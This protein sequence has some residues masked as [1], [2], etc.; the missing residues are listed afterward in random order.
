[1]NMQNLMMQAK[2]MQ[3]DIVKIQDELEKKTYEGKSQMVTILIN[4]K[5]KILSVNIDDSIFTSEDK[6][7]LEDM[8]LIAIN[9]ALEKM[10]TDKEEKLGKYSKMFNGL[11]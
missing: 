3:N 10:N 9:D 7:V 4:G 1:M 2:K 11:M 8:I 6:E 5:G